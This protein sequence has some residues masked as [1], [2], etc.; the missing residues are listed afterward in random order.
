[1]DPSNPNKLFAGMWEFR[2][3]PWFFESGG[4]GSGLYR[5]P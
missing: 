3:W 4:P 2:R 5:D 1:M